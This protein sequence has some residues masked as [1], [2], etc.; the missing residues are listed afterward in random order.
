M[1]E[2]KDSSN[3]RW[4]KDTLNSEIKKIN[5]EKNALEWEIE[6]LRQHIEEQENNEDIK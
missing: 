6:M 2:K 3:W 5:I 4:Q 1:Y